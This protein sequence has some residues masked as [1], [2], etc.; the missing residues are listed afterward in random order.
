MTARE[1]STRPGRRERKKASTRAAIQRHALRL[2]GEQ[3]Y[4]ATTMNQIAEAADVSPSTLFRYFPTKEALVQWDEYDP[5]FMAAVRA[6]PAR[7]SAIAALRAAMRDLFEQLSPEDRAVL[8]E[9]ITLLA[10][11]P[12]LR[13]M[14]ADHLSGPAQML[15]EALAERSGREASDLA[16]QVMVGAVI[17][18]G[19]AVMVAAA[20]DPQAD[21]VAMIEAA[22][23]QLEAGLPL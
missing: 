3:G 16:V 4:E 7:L 6:Q 15:A 10:A 5:V 2:F 18:A 8:R 23:A 22:M 1:L 21:I 19:V 17:G 12:L 9:R 11:I 14:S 13:S 20:Q